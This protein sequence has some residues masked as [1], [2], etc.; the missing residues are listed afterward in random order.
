MWRPKVG[1][2]YW[3]VDRTGAV[4]GT[5]YG[6]LPMGPIEDGI[7]A[8][9]NCFKT[10]ENA[11]AA[12]RDI[13]KLLEDTHAILYDWDRVWNLNV[14]LDPKIIARGMGFHK[15]D[16]SKHK[17]PPHYQMTPEPLEVIQAWGLDFAKGSALKYIARAGKKA[18]ED[19]TTALRKAVDFLQ[20]E[21][22]RLEE[23]GNG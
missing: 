9:G 7:V 8:F 15:L 17:T 18:G 1:E 22:K 23:K 16:I 10:R 2:K 3:Y 4:V 13:A 19:E 11:M 12:K 20:R 6:K 21:I 5:C 14:F